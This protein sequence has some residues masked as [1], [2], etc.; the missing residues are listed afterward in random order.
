MIKHY[1]NRNEI[2]IVLDSY[3]YLVLYYNSEIWM[4]PA[5]KLN[6]RQQLLSASSFALRICSTQPNPHISFIDLHKHNS[7]SMA[8]HYSQYKLSL[9][10]FKA[11]NTNMQDTD[12]QNCNKL[13]IFTTGRQTKFIMFKRITT[14]LA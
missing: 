6:L 13:F 1:F 11:F 12:W 4:L 5:L 8:E 3:F 10:L 9:L 7:E 2:K 14:K